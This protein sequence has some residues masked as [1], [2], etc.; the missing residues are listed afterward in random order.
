[1]EKRAFVNCIRSLYNIDGH[2]LPELSVQQ[3]LEFL[4]IPFDFSWSR[5]SCSPTPSCGKSRGDSRPRNGSP[6]GSG[7]SRHHE[8]GA[9]EEGQ[10]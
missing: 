7:A 5:T 3:Q 6:R 9:P 2:L 1:M 8:G 4:R 10:G